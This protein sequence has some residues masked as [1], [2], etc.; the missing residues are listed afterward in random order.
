MTTSK[1]LPVWQAYKNMVQH[2][3]FSTNRNIAVYKW[4]ILLYHWCS[5]LEYVAVLI[6][7]SVA[8]KLL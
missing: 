7:Q 2:I 5:L 1:N 4:N 6:L 8:S 3:A